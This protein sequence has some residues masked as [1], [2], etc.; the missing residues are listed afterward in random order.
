MATLSE[1]R[2]DLV[3]V[4]LVLSA[5][6]AGLLVWEYV[7][8]IYRGIKTR[9]DNRFKCHKCSDPCKRDRSSVCVMC[10]HRFCEIHAIHVRNL[11]EKQWMALTAHQPVRENSI[12]CEPCY[13][14]SSI[15]LFGS[16]YGGSGSGWFYDD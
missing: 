10:G 12:V 7:P 4:V 8:P 11:E 6:M 3:V 14:N 2:V 15:P 1:F 9:N 5:L 13:R 16:S